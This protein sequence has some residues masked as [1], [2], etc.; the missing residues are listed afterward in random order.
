MSGDVPGQALSGPKPKMVRLTLGALVSYID[1]YC[2]ARGLDFS[3]NPLGAQDRPPPEAKERHNKT[4]WRYR[5]RRYR[6][7]TRTLKMRR[8]WIN[9]QKLLW[10]H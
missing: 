1:H 5:R 2:K 4:S 8:K 9:G 10:R 3:G 7:G 6:R